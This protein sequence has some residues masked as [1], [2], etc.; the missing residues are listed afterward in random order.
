MLISFDWLKDYVS[1]NESASQVAKKLTM[2]GIEVSSIEK[3]KND[4]VFDAEITPN[5]PDLLSVQGIAREVAA[6]TSR[7][8]KEPA[9]KSR[10]LPRA[11][12]NIDIKIEDTIACKRYNATLIKDVSVKVAPQLVTRRL[13]ALDVRPVNNIVDITNFHLMD[14]GQPLHAFD[15]DK[16]EG[17]RVIVRRAVKG[18]KI[19]AINGKEYKLDED[20]LVIADEKKPIAIAGIMGGVDTEIGLET[21]NILLECAHFDA[22]T[23]RRASSKLG[24]KSD[25]SYRFERGIC[26]ED[27]PEVAARAAG[28]IEEATGGKAAGNIDISDYKPQ[29]LKLELRIAEIKRILGV[30]IEADKAASILQSLG[31]NVSGR[32]KDKCIVGIP[33]F[34][35]D[36][37]REVDLIEEVARIYG[38]DN[39]PDTLA[40]IYPKQIKKYQSTGG[41]REDAK[42]AIKNIIRQHLR[43]CG[44]YEII[45]YSLINEREAETMGYAE[46]ETARL[47]NPLSQEQEILRPSLVPGLLQCLTWNL[48]RQIDNVPVF[49]LGKVF[50]R[51]QS[52]VKEKLNVGFCLCGHKFTGDWQIKP[53]PVN[54]YDV[55]GI[56]ESLL[57]SL[58]L[59]KYSVEPAKKEYFKEAKAASVLRV[60]EEVAVF[61]EIDEM[62]LDVY[63]IETPVFAAEI[64]L[65]KLLPEIKLE[66]S[67]ERIPKYPSISR[68]LAVIVKEDLESRVVVD[69]IK[70]VG[71]KLITDISLF[72]IYTGRQIPPGYKSLAYSITYQSPRRTLT[73]KEIDDIQTEIQRKLVEDLKAQIR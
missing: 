72:D 66:F 63:D 4:Y 25:S 48:N 46:E 43:A 39:I 5:R 24:L 38:Y 67:L 50:Y 12:S 61:G 71:K 30:D 57:K 51:K 73:D 1:I 60:K 37:A 11:G 65:E 26:I 64:Y 15:Y 49:E 68:D 31:M 55:K 47:I 3:V 36:I 58:R 29:G 32:Q 17:G 9:A 70:K 20:I 19:T 23:I 14:S 33:P 40:R 41:V 62:L 56:I 10:Q 8:M 54:F 44:L 34:R 59:N 35:Q 45:S 16:I 13:N 69:E 22:I 7:K 53:K 42:Y 27:I 52:E 21:K 18:E 28:D 6:L 2:A